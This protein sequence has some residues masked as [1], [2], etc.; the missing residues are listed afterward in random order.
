MKMENIAGK[1]HNVKF[2]CLDLHLSFNFFYL[3]TCNCKIFLSWR[4]IGEFFSRIGWY[5]LSQILRGFRNLSYLGQRLKAKFLSKDPTYHKLTTSS[6]QL[7]FYLQERYNFVQIHRHLCWTILGPIPFW[8][9]LPTKR[10]SLKLLNQSKEQLFC[11]I[12]V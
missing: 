2:Y 10:L 8:E 9:N 12:F 7:L 3:I 4:S 11:W 6:L 1:I 5:S